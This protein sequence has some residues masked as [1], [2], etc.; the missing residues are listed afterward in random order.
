[1]TTA[2]AM[3]R[4]EY[5]G[6]IA[7]DVKKLEAAGAPPQ[8]IHE[9]L[10]KYDVSPAELLE[11]DATLPGWLATALQG[12]TLSGSDEL[13]A[14]ASSLVTGKPYSQELAEERAGLQ[15][16]RNRNPVA[17]TGLE[18]L[19]ALPLGMVGA[20]RAAGMGMGRRM[21]AAGLEGA[22]AG[23][24]QGY[25]ASEGGAGNRLGGAVDGAIFGGSLGAM[26]PPAMA[27]GGGLRRALA[28]QF[29]IK[30]SPV[31][32]A[33]GRLAR[34]IADDAEHLKR[35]REAAG[36]Q[37]ADGFAGALRE[38]QEG[39]ADRQVDAPEMFL[40]DMGPNLQAEL[41]R[42]ARTPGPSSDIARRA[43]QERALGSRNRTLAALYGGLDANRDLP[44]E[45]LQ[46]IQRR[47][48]AEARDLFGAYRA[49]ELKPTQALLQLTDMPQVR[50]ALER[51]QNDVA[52]QAF[53]EDLAPD[54]A[55]RS[56]MQRM[57][58][59]AY[60]KIRDDAGAAA[61][62]GRNGEA[63]TLT[64]LS[65][66]LKR[67]ID[68]SVDG[69]FVPALERYA[70]ASDLMD[71]LDEGRRIIG[72]K[73]AREFR[74]AVTKWQRKGDDAMDQFRRGVIEGIEDK[75][76]QSPN[77]ER[78]NSL[79]RQPN[80]REQL[81]LVFPDELAFQR[82]ASRMDAEGAMES[83]RYR[84]IGNSLTD[85]RALQRADVEEG[86]GDVVADS[87][88]EGRGLVGT[89]GMALRHLRG[90]MVSIPKRERDRI[91]A[92]VLTETDPQVLAVS[93]RLIMDKIDDA[94]KVQ[95]M[96]AIRQLRAGRLAGATAGNWA[97]VEERPA[98]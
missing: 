18:M 71:A 47:R 61:R 76:G 56:G 54:E 74:E 73:G 49:A 29:G 14:G 30:Q 6:L 7:E 96:R 40:A 3:T 83:T 81:R 43:L 67:E 38:A 2:L 24:T 94:Q 52:T 20:G 89:A 69:T 97:A 95:V 77:P 36:R 1:M 86:I 93:L 8:Q 66:A 26:I 12:T 68:K 44:E 60:A 82:F 65:H 35:A 39:L 13:I 55:A 22:G 85:E 15:G 41:G 63:R 34:T 53:L 87:L 98:W 37:P 5:L 33:A 91:L 19:G 72:T 11:R 90:A 16:F 45:I 88:M 62:A 21:L 4:E 50:S 10:A 25:L 70:D 42:V 27:G 84:A 31:D 51:A 59:L 46:G 75:A 79:W 9:Y 57:L 32:M 28:A 17:A 23:A 48:A 64:Q 80:L 78:I 58:H 92:T